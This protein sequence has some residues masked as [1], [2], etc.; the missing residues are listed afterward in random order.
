[1][2]LGGKEDFFIQTAMPDQDIGSAAPKDDEAGAIEWQQGF[3]VCAFWS[4]DFSARHDS[5][6][7]ITPL[8][9]VCKCLCICYGF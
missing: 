2:L 7:H 9:C 8:I 6:L 3:K 4:V 5:E 1:M